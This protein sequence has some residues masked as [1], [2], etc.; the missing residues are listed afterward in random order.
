MARAG[1]AFQDD[2]DQAMEETPLLCGCGGGE[3]PWLLL[4]MYSRRIAALLAIAGVMLGSAWRSLANKCNREKVGVGM[5]VFLLALQCSDVF[6][7]ERHFISH[8]TVSG[9]NQRTWSP[10][11]QAERDGKPPGNSAFSLGFPCCFYFPPLSLQPFVLAT[12]TPCEGL[13][14]EVGDILRGC[15]SPNLMLPALLR[16]WEAS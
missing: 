5:G 3:W 4:V 12:L 2:Q 7:G 1:T 13:G 6:P 15:S 14:A 10:P 16:G 11:S 8:L 9:F